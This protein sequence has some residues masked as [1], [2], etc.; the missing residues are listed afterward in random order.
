[1]PW[2]W[3]RKS[4]KACMNSHSAVLAR[5]WVV[6][7]LEQQLDNVAIL[8][9]YSVTLLHFLCLFWGPNDCNQIRRVP[10][11]PCCILF[12]LYT[13]IHLSVPFSFMLK[14]YTGIPQ[15]TDLYDMYHLCVCT[16]V[17]MCVWGNALSPL[18]YSHMSHA[19]TFLGLMSWAVK[20]GWGLLLILWGL[21]IL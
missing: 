20:A 4:A 11:Y 1:M 16:R 12:R 18:Y 17:L 10:N 8:V 15:I 9:S 6:S 19:L 5:Q 3:C 13:E 2:Y 14:S 7:L 21:W